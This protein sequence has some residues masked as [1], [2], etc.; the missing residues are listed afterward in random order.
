MKIRATLLLLVL[1][2]GIFTGCL[3]RKGQEVQT[4]Q[5]EYITLT[6]YGLFDDEE[7][8]SGIIQ[9]FQN[10]NPHVTIDYKKFTDPEDYLDLIINELA[11]GEGPD[12]FMMHNTWFPRHYKKLTPAPESI[13][14]AEVFRSLFVEVT[15]EELIIPDESNVEQVWG[16]PIYVDTLAVYYNKDHY[17]DAVP[18]RGRPGDTWEEIQDDVVELNKED[19]S[20]SRFERSGAALGRH[21]N[22]L[23]AFDILMAMMLQYGVDFYSDDL[24]EAVFGSDPGAISALELYTSFALPSKKNYSWNKYL[25][26]EDSST[27]EITAFAEGTVSMIFGYSYL[28]EDILDEIKHLKS[29]GEDT[30]SSTDVKI[31]ELPQVYDPDTSAET[32]ETWASYFVPVVSRTTEYPEEAWEFLATMV[33]E[34][35]LRSYNE[36]THRPSALRSLITEQ[37]QIPV[38]D[39]FATQVGY[40]TSIPMADPAAYEEI[41]LNAIE[42]ILGTARVE[43]VLRSAEDDVQALIPSSGVKPVYI[44]E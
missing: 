35:N 30:I 3:R 4:G 9:N 33:D 26:D 14:N 19:Q 8:Y 1:S 29:L 12:M 38:Y 43:D 23:R 16:L 28:Y 15:G 13:V 20:F 6:F 5:Q 39:V 36:L 27:M 37:E 21:D 18:T 10:E 32:R 7:L 17:E 40:A 34:E 42:R 31:Q 41:I 44:P 2:L 24:S 22:I 25:S 11:E